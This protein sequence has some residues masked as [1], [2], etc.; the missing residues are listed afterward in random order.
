MNRHRKPRRCSRTWRANAGAIPMEVWFR[1]GE[2]YERR[3]NDPVKAKVAYA[4]VP[5]DRR[6]TATRSGSEARR[7]PSRAIGSRSAR[8]D[9]ER[10][11]RLAFAERRFSPPWS[12][13]SF[14]VNGIWDLIVAVQR[15][16]QDARV[17]GTLGQ[18][19]ANIAVERAQPQQAVGRQ[20]RVGQR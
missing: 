2:I 18:R 17:G 13:R 9:V 8:H 4:K 7:Q 12:P 6:A 10:N 5:R 16:G 11:H 15:E 19:Q 14:I 20:S 1:L 3:L